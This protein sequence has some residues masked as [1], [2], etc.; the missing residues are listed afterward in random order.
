MENI[1]VKEPMINKQIYE[2]YSLECIDFVQKALVKN[3]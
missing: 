3:P 2:K 1:L